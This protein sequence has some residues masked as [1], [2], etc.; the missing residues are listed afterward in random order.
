MLSGIGP[1]AHLKSHSITP[2]LDHPGVGQRLVDHPVVDLYF[3]NKLNN[4]PK[5]LKPS[6]LY[7]VGKLIS[8]IVQ[9]N[10]GKGGPLAMNVRELF[11]LSVCLI[12]NLVVFSSV[13]AL[14]SFARMTRRC[15]LSASTPTNW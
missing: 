9:Y 11:L 7:E 8:A 3:K 14:R 5:F 2:V 6:N 13:N 15:S 4:S 12:D 10:L 1:A